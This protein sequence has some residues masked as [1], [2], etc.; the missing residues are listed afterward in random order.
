MRE[1]L[2]NQEQTILGGIATTDLVDELC[3]RFELSNANQFLT[4][5]RIELLRQ[6]LQDPTTGTL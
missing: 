1:N 2:T 4:Q 5:N 3:A 6:V